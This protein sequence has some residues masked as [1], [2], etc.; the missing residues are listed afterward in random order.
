MK[1]YFILLVMLTSFCS[2][3][4]QDNIDKLFK[5][6]LNVIRSTVMVNKWGSDTTYYLD[7]S[8]ENIS[9]DTLVYITNSCFYY[10]HYSLKTS[11]QEFDLNPIG[12]CSFNELTYHTLAP[13]EAFN[14]SEEF[15][16]GDL[17]LL[18]AG[19]WYVTLKVPL[20]KDA[21]G[22]RVDGRDFIQ[23]KQYL[24]YNGTAVVVQVMVTKQKKQ[25]TKNE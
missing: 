18:K 6:N 21:R 11:E 5:I 25:K 3:Y 19:N 8:V 14:I 16:A 17:S 7:Y 4:A 23:D 1:I 9:T 10:N 2:V 24:I 22:Y 20:V 12:S 15:I 13:G